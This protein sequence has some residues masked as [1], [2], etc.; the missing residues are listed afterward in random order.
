MAPFHG[1]RKPPTEYVK[2]KAGRPK[3]RPLI[4]VVV[5]PIKLDSVVS[6]DLGKQAT[7]W[8]LLVGD[9]II[10][11]GKIRMGHLK[12]A[13]AIFN[14]L[15][16][17]V[18]RILKSYAEVAD[19]VAYEN[20]FAQSG[21]AREAFLSL[22]MALKV[23]AYRAELPIY[24]VSPMQVKKAVT[25]RGR[26]EGKS[27]IVQHINDRFGMYLDESETGTDHNIADAI[28]VALAAYKLA[29]DGKLKEAY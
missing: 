10:D 7:G 11:Y 20:A 14:Q 21:L 27:I 18:S 12:G 3:K 9:D 24:V 4:D 19:G 29:A 22:A 25:G 6:I 5:K 2:K 13:V 23:S 8:A 17:E 26:V 16:E 1:S 15:L 28:G